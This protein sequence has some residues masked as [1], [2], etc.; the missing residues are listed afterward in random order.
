MAAE[1]SEH[2]ATDQSVDGGPE[3]P[4]PQSSASGPAIEADEIL[5][6]DGRLFVLERDSREYRHHLV[7]FEDA[8][9]TQIVTVGVLE[10]VFAIFLAVTVWTQYRVKVEATK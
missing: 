10:V 7:Q 9:I 6:V 1:R 3:A 5:N 8:L 4:P 2:E